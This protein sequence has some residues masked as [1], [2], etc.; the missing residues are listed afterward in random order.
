M[1]YFE[2][3]NHS[4][5]NN[6]VCKILPNSHPFVSNRYGISRFDGVPLTDQFDLH[7]FLVNF[8]EESISKLIVNFK[9]GADYGFG[10]V[11]MLEFHRNSYLVMAM[12]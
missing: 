12:N 4:I 9:S 10:D 2:F 6:K 11:F 3:D 1:G 7:G 8:F 5:I